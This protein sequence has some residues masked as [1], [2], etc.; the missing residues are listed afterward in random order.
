MP[1][2]GPWGGEIVAGRRQIACRE[3]QPWQRVRRGDSAGFEPALDQEHP[4]ANRFRKHRKSFPVSVGGV[5]EA[6]QLA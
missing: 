1:A 5:V 6:S 4:A 3:P 2:A